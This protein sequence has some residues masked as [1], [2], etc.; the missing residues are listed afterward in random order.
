MESTVVL[1]VVL[2]VVAAIVGAVVTVLLQPFA[3]S[4]LSP[5]AKKGAH[6][7]LNLLANLRK[8]PRIEYVITHNSNLMADSVKHFSN[9]KVSQNNGIIAEPKVAEIKFKSIGA[10]SIAFDLFQENPITL[11]FSEEVSI[12]DAKAYLE[13]EVDVKIDFSNANSIVLDLQGSCLDPTESLSVYVL[14]SSAQI[15]T[16][17]VKGS[18]NGI[19]LVSRMKSNLK[20]SKR[21]YLVLAIGIAIYTIIFSIIAI[22]QDQFFPIGLLFIISLGVVGVALCIRNFKNTNSKVIMS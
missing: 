11:S 7:L 9:L 15:D 22:N 6:Y 12:E 19:E 2:S 5:I 8:L 13:G 3:E 10:S 18:A 16:P 4:L 17:N 20:W 21:F 14:Y 1:S